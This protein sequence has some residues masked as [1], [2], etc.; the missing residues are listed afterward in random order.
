[1]SVN[2]PER[3]GTALAITMIT[4]TTQCPECHTQFDVAADDLR[5]RKGLVR[6]IQ[7]HEIFD[8][9][10]AVVEG[11]AKQTIA[12][13]V[14][15]DTVS[16][17]VH[18]PFIVADTQPAAP[19]FFIIDTPADQEPLVGDGADLAPPLY[20]ERRIEPVVWSWR[21]TVKK[22]LGL[23][24][25]WGLILLAIA[26][27]MYVYRAQL[28]LHA[29]FMRPVLQ[30]LC[31][32]IGCQVPY[33]RA[34]KAIELTYSR[35]SFE[36]AVGGEHSYLLQVGMRNSAAVPQE[37]PSLLITL[38]DVS[39]TVLARLEIKPEQYLSAAQSKGPFL[40]GQ[41]VDIRLQ[42]KA[43]D[44]KINGFKVEKFFS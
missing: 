22:W 19:D 16:E 38:S 9:Y 34:I 5:R 7:C 44:T 3:N 18:P 25:L 26:Q 41:T 2:A 14:A 10:E 36:G 35:L 40:P 1:M 33:L 15:A 23:L 28:A 17:S 43:Q 13:T 11:A 12:D 30:S 42:I 21:T 32:S 37:W 31:A 8:G 20:V 39:A 24:L 29:P 4:L 6:C 27:G